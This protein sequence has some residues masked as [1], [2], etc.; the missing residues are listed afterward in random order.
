MAGFISLLIATSD[1]IWGPRYMHV[2][3][4]PLLV[5]IGAA[6]PRLEWKIGLA[7]AGLAV[8]GF[9]FSFL[10]A[11]SSYGAPSSAMRDAAQNTMEWING[12][13]AWGGPYFESQLV[14]AWWT[15]GNGPVFWVA[16]HHW[17]WEPP[18]NFPAEWRTIDL[19]DY[20]TPQSILLQYWNAKPEG[21]QRVTFRL[22]LF[23]VIAGP[24]MLLFA[25]LRT[26]KESRV[27]RS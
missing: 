19:R 9:A 17:V 7:L 1:E 25:A 6:W 23:S 26:W 22:S 13:S 27:V 11:F 15:P 10:G 4:A 20:S 12:D 2:A 24:L 14:R 8:T 21:A 5:C 3:I 18:E 16:S